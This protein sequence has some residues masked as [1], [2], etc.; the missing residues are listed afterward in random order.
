MDIHTPRTI[1][2]WMAATVLVHLLV[3]MIHGAAH[4]WAS[5]P[6]S[7]AANLFVFVVILAG[8]L[9]GLG[10]SFRTR[11]YG[12]VVVALT[13]AASLVFGVVNHFLIDS[14]DH[15][16]HIATPW[17][18]LFVT[19]AVLLTI[20]ELLGLAFALRLGPTAHGELTPRAARD[21]SGIRITAIIMPPFRGTG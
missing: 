12:G 13:M 6:M 9:I 11:L 5:V 2:K 3:S 16:S 4:A 21:Y 14:P 17:S 19:T 10:I 1:W 15:I 18:R 8:P 7:Q 20:T